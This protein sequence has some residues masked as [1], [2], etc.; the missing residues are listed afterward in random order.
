MLNGNIRQ[1]PIQQAGPFVT[2][3]DN[4]RPF[5]WTS[6]TSTVSSNSIYN[7][8][9]P[10]FRL[11]DD[12]SAPVFANNSPL[13]LSWRNPRNEMSGDLSSPIK[14]R[15]SSSTMSDHETWDEDDDS[16]EGSRIYP[17]RSGE[18]ATTSFRSR[19]PCSVSS[20]ELMES[21]F[22]SKSGPITLTGKSKTGSTDTSWLEDKL[23]RDLSSIMPTFEF[24]NNSFKRL[25]DR[26]MFSSSS[27][28]ETST[29]ESQHISYCSSPEFEPRF[30]RHSW[31][32]NL[33][34]IDSDTETL[35]RLNENS[36]RPKRDRSR[37]RRNSFDNSFRYR[38]PSSEKGTLKRNQNQNE[39]N[40]LTYLR[41]ESQTKCNHNERG[42]PVLKRLI[43]SR[44]NS[45][46]LIIE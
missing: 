15:S 16:T 41:F 33:E 13:Q 30:P 4:H 43:K 29:D 11:K 2:H 38:K 39:E 14:Y 37:S 25:S 32:S 22:D 26:P 34:I 12:L 24:S 5:S 9:E 10:V 18:L 20:E 44:S 19:D 45:S 17:I 8:S 46:E 3:S 7:K 23:A 21:V 35:G 31:A 6:S 42:L 27:D 40:K 36:K 1:A 28:S